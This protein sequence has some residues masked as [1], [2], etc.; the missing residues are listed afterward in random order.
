MNLRTALCLVPVLLAATSHA[1]E[2]TVEPKLFV[3]EKS[4][5]ATAL[6]DAGAV[7]LQTEAKA[8]TDFQI[9]QIAAQGSNVSK[10]AVLVKFDSEEIDK[11]IIDSR[12]SLVSGELTLAQATQD[13]KTLEETSPNKLEAYRRAAR[14]AKEENVYFTLTRR[15][16]S[17]ESAAQTLKRT[18]E[19]LENEQEELK[20]LTAMYQA[21][22]ITEETEEII[23]TRQKDSV[24]AA[25]FAL[26]MET[27]NHKRVMEVT[28]PREAVIF[29]E[30]ERDTAIALA[31]AELDIPRAIQL[32]K[33]E[34]EG[35]KTARER[36][37]KSLAE[38]EQDRT[39]FEI[40]AP[41]DGWFYHGPIENGRWSPN[42]EL[43][44]TLVIHGRTPINRPIATFVPATA[45]LALVAF[46]DEA[47]ARI[48]KAGIAGTATLAGR[49]DL[50]I[51]ATLNTL[52]VTPG[53]DGTYRADLSATWPKD[54]NPVTGSTAKL[55]LEAYRNDKAITVPVKAIT[56]SPG[57][58]TVDVK[59]TDG[60]TEKR[61][62]KR[63]RSSSEETEILSGLEVGQV[64]VTP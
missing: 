26:K 1:G 52:A 57:G 2:V 51:P 15:K 34:L 44:K 48:L 39:L 45:K 19:R 10:G 3:V 50:E 41:A 27:L 20:Q 62:V 11:K 24:V 63:G 49:E 35:L 60:K 25:E 61:V 38:L 13:L 58:W 21:D 43:L 18:K 14:I 56:R 64:I 12:R 23:L 29:A 54:L 6:P 33:L 37:L 8:W 42:P 40:K 28:L 4:F 36:E 47:T 17:E 7:L 22:D 59:L 55:T 46:L 31:K 16:A 32:K 53:A 9:T 5:S 30:S